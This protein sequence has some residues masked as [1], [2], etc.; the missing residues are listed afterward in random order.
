MLPVYEVV[1]QR[2]LQRLDAIGQQLNAESLA[3]GG[4]SRRRRSGHEHELDAL[5][6]RYLI[7]NLGDT[8]FLQ[9]F[10]HVDDV[11]GMARIDEFVEVT[12][13]THTE[14]VLPVVVL[15]EDA[16]H[17]VLMGHLWQ[18]VRVLQ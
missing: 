3:R 4:L 10:R 6:G 18:H 7:G 15:L 13:R 14:D 9:R 17:L 12:Y 2:Y 11:G 1:I 5:A 16:E 8:L